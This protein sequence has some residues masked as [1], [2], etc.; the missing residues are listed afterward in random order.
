LDKF[1]RFQL[2]HRHFRSHRQPVPISRLAELLECSE[3][4]VKRSMEQMR[5]Y[6]G[7]PIE[8]F[9]EQRGWQYSGWGQPDTADLYELPGL[10][11]TGN[12]LQSMA[13]LIQLLETFGNGLLNDELGVITRNIT[14]L[15]DARGIRRSAFEQHIKVLPL[16]NR[17]IA[18][19]LFG[20]VCEALLTR[21]QLAIQYSNYKNQPS[22]R[23]ISPQT[24]VYYRENWYLD[25]WCHLRQDLR[26][27]SLARI[28]KL[29]LQKDRSHPV[30][31]Q[32]L[33]T[34][35]SQGYGIFSGPANHKAVLRFSSEIAREVAM[36]QWHPAQR[37][38]WQGS[39]YVL[40]IP[41]SD[42]RELIQDILRHVPHVVVVAPVKLRKAV[43]RRL[44]EGLEVFS[45]KRIPKP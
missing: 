12:E 4:T 10:W 33:K 9:S 40:S 42:D 14:R 31:P 25:A 23:L 38:E 1:D 28:E 39:D 24:L 2:L 36:Q 45:G 44:H 22:K 3:K 26:T 18:N 13:M 29:S 37:G 20:Q 41:Y 7:A 27:F 43:Q 30:D 19:P 16:N 34:H 5:D 15:L 17:Y 21:Q 8:Y 32:Q 11:L 35:F 6:L